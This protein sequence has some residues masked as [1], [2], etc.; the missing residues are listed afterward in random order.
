MCVCVWWMSGFWLYLL[1]FNKALYIS[2]I[3]YDN[4]RLKHILYTYNSFC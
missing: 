2:G 4:L 3:H 1:Q